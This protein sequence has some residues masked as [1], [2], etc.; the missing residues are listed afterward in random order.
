MVSMNRCI[1]A[2]GMNE[3]LN[4]DGPFTVFAPS[5][6]AFGKLQRGAM[7][8][9]LNP[10]NKT[11]LIETVNHHIVRRKINFDEFKDGQTLKPLYGDDLLVRVINGKVTVNSAIIQNRDVSS[12]NGVIHSLDG[13][14]KN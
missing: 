7:E 2:S 1:M 3:V 8:F 10:V 13:L 6:L 9:F 12:S 11:K 14:L 4:E 5:D